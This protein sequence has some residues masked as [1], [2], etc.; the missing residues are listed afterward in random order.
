M[1]KAEMQGAPTRYLKNRF[2]KTLNV[3]VD[4]DLNPEFQFHQTPSWRQFLA[5]L[6]THPVKPKLEK[7]IDLF[8]QFQRAISCASFFRPSIHGKIWLA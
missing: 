1:F 3:M 7:A 4:K 8:G 5:T 2:A 6:I